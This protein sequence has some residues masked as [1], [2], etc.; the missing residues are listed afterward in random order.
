MS[1]TF[2]FLMSPTQFKTFHSK[3]ELLFI[4]TSSSVHFFHMALCGRQVFTGGSLVFLMPGAL[5]AE[6]TS[7]CW[8]SYLCSEVICPCSSPYLKNILMINFSQYAIRSHMVTYMVIY[9]LK[10]IDPL[11]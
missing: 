11:C 4:I 3:V 2:L 10:S 8:F 1:I 9:M 6:C 7:E 5:A